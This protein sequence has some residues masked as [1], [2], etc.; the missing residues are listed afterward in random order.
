MVNELRTRIPKGR[1]PEKVTGERGG[2]RNPRQQYR[3]GFRIKMP[4]G[5]VIYRVARETRVF[6]KQQRRN[7][8]IADT[9]GTV[10]GKGVYERTETE[11]SD[12]RWNDSGLSYADGYAVIHDGKFHH[13]YKINRS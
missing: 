8:S 5:S 9:I 10:S 13:V 1:N 2:Y 6:T 12:G 3:K 11:G 7:M 4:D